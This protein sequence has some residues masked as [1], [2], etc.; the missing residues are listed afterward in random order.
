MRRSAALLLLLLVAA[1]CVKAPPRTEP[2]VGVDVPEEWS[3]DDVATGE[4]DGDWWESF[5]DANLDELID[6]ALERNWDLQAAVARVERAEAQARIAGADLKPGIDAGLNAGQQKVNFPGFPISGSNTFSRYDASVNVFW[7]VDLWGRLRAGARAAVADVQASESDLRGVRLSLA[8]RTAKLW[9]AIAEAQEQAELSRSSAESFRNVADQVR[10]RYEKGVRP[11]L[12]LRLALSN[13]T[14]AEASLELRKNQLDALIRQL[15]VLIGDYPDR[16]LEEAFAIE[17]LLPTPP[18]VP[19]GLP[20]DLVARRPDLVSAERRLA[21]ADQRLVAAKRSL[22]PRLALTASGGAATEE[23][24]DLL[25]GDFSVWSLAANLAQPIFQGGRIRAN[26]AG[27]AATREEVLAIYAGSVLQAYAEVETALASE[28]F[29]RER[30][31]HLAASVHQL[32]A[33][34]RLADERYRYGVGGYLELL[35]S[36]TRSFITQSELLTV[37]RQRLENRV[38]L[39]LALG[40]GF[41]FTP[42]ETTAPAPGTTES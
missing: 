25:N 34:E 41:E 17:D 37:R 27:S 2:D 26:I 10:S 32:V 5:D 6:L 1:S 18:P 42:D 40:G 24:G 8:G 22:Y 3:A 28:R 31:R 15:E 36:Q 14:A 19:A 29:L 16:D 38:N 33:A 13:L 20:A 9:F 21:A 7:E 23:F 4:I 39:H 12:D 11:A 35:E 30:E